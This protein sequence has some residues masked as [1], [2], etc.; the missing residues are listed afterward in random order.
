MHAWTLPR[1]DRV[2]ASVPRGG[3]DATTRVAAEDGA[4]EVILEIFFLNKPSGN[5]SS[6]TLCDGSSLAREADV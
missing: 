3:M 5:T 4:L 6:A 1:R 2:K